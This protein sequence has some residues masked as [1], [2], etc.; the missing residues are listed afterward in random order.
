MRLLI[1][2]LSRFH[3][4]GDFRARSLAR[5]RVFVCLCLF[6]WLV[7]LCFFKLP[8]RKE[9]LFLA[10]NQKN[11]LKLVNAAKYLSCRGNE[12]V[13][14]SADNHNSDNQPTKKSLK[15][16]SNNGINP[17]SLE[18]K[19]HILPTVLCTFL[20]EVVRRI[21]L[22]ITEYISSLVITSFILIA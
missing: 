22:N 19:M 3:A 10:M 6:V 13:P 4:A 2:Y 16:V 15:T 17:L 21:C 5:A 14:R 1:T 20:M 18:I 9:R 11:H 7:F 8:E 12:I